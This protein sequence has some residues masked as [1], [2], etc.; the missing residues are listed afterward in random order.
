[1]KRS[2]IKLRLTLWYTLLMLLMAAVTLTFVMVISS[3]V[4]NQTVLD[5]LDR[6]LRENALQADIV[7]GELEIGSGFGFYRSGIYTVVYSKSQALLAGQ[8]PQA[9]TALTIPFE[10]G[11]TRPVE[12]EQGS[13]YVMDLW[14]PSGWEDGIWLRGMTEIS[15]G[16]EA[17]QNLLIAA[18]IAL[19][20]FILLGALGGW[21]IV[22]RALRPLDSINATA[23]AI[24]EGRDL[25][26]RIDLGEAPEEFRRLGE[27]F[28]RMLERLER[29]FEA[30]KRFTSDASHELRTPLSVILSAC[31]YSEKFDETVEEQRETIQTVHRQ[32]KKMAQLINQL[33]QMTRLDQGTEKLNMEL[34]DL[35]AL[36]EE[37]CRDQGERCACL[38]TDI[39]PG[40]KVRGDRLLLTRLIQNLL[41]NAY[42]YGKPGGSVW[43]SLRREGGQVQLSVRDEGEGIAPELQEKIWQRFYQAD[44]SRSGAQGAG[45]GLAMVEQIA[46]LHGGDMSLESRPGEGSVFT[47]R[48]PAAADDAGEKTLKIFSS[49]MFL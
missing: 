4:A 24:N 46:R 18:G 38:K 47:L 2:S 20:L 12:T 25:S 48:L 27:N 37:L 7:D 16:A 15:Q 36:G 35:S 41:D 3:S 19:P 28:D 8:L 42:K 49:F 40:V 45:L 33:L 39:L 5:S 21:L 29:A 31:E 43:L 17:R 11:L 32:G 30:E 6:T 13:Y 44:P 9:L 23:A 1:M 26:A 22:R 14:L 34:L 10:N